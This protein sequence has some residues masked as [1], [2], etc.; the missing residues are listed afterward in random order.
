MGAFGLPHHTGAAVAVRA[1]RRLLIRDVRGP[2][3][4]EVGEHYPL[5]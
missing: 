2:G 3:A 1:E 5:G 4:V